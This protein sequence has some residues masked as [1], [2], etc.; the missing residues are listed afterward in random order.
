MELV[1]QEPPHLA[2]DPL[3]STVNSLRR[4]N[5]LFIPIETA[6][7]TTPNS[8]NSFGSHRFY[9]CKDQVDSRLLKYITQIVVSLTMIGVSIS[10][11]VTKGGDQRLF[12]SSLLSFV[13]GIWLPNPK[14]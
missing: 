1:E 2:E 4:S 13:I 9:M 14:K 3:E 6:A 8:E 12:W 10:Q 7:P 11:L 5:S